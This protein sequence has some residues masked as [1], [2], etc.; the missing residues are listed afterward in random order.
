MDEPPPPQATK[1]RDRANAAMSITNFFMV[2]PFRAS[3]RRDSVYVGRTRPRCNYVSGATNGSVDDAGPKRSTSVRLS[4]SLV[5]PEDKTYPEERRGAEAVI[6][7][8]VSDEALMV[9]AQD[10]DV[11][12]FAELYVRHADGR[13]GRR[14]RDRRDPGRAEDA[15]QDGFFSIWRSR[16]DYRPQVG[17]F[18][19]WAMRIIHNRAVDSL[20]V[21]RGQP[22]LQ[23]AEQDDDS[24]KGR[25]RRP[26]RAR[27]RRLERARLFE[28]LRRLP[29]PPDRGDRPLLLRRLSHSEIATRLGVPPGTVKGRMRLGL[30]K[31]RGEWPVEE[32]GTARK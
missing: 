23:A 7:T 2:V 1:A 13:A 31:L 30:Q 21:V 14:R 29:G 26:V 4:Y 17:S 18:E 8:A 24:P 20:R 12:A 3:R 19:A 27:G 11:E 10:D 6:S 32:R 9:R 25:C 15:V 28:A 5:P 22:R 16:A